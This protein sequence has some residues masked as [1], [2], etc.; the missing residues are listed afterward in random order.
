MRNDMFKV[1]VERPR[2]R[3]ISDGARQFRNSEDVPAKIGVRR[4][5]RSR[6]YLNENLA[7]LRRFLQSQAGRPWDSVYS[8]VRET[9]DGRSTVKQHILQ[10]IED[11][12]AIHTREVNGEIVAQWRWRSEQPL[13]EL[14]QPLYV[15]PNSGFLLRN[16]APIR[17]RQRVRATRARD[18]REVAAKRRILDARRQLHKV[19]G[20]W[21]LVE[22]AQLPPSRTETRVVNGAPKE[23]AVHE[24]RWD[25]LHKTWVFR[26]SKPLA[27]SADAYGQPGLYAITKRQLSWRDAKRYGV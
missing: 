6:K 24:P 2:K 12:V 25:V 4:G 7:P 22:V 16:T 5:Y 14:R 15:D 18:A 9:I 8:E 17:Q 21:F 26:G 27:A 11:F 19:E 13:A 20:N 1:I 23:H 3:A 10:H